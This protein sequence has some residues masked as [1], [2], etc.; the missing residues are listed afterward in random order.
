MVIKH[1]E[2]FRQKKNVERNVIG[3]Q[4]LYATQLHLHRAM[5]FL[6]LESLNIAPSQSHFLIHLDLEPPPHKHRAMHRRI[7]AH[8]GHPCF[9]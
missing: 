8:D 6:Q 7:G 3:D 1:K 2:I 5:H 9:I 4:Y